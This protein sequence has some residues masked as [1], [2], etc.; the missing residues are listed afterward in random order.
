MF[1]YSSLIL[2]M[3]CL[4]GCNG[5][6][7]SDIFSSESSGA[8]SSTVASP[9]TAESS[10]ARSATEHEASSANTISSMV[11]V[12]SSASTAQSSANTQP[13]RWQP[14]PLTTWQWQ[15][16]GS[17]NENYPVQA[18]DIDL[19][20]TSA[21]T[22]AALQTQG[23]RII[24]YFSAGSYEEWRQDALSFPT[25]ALGNNLDGWP[26]ERWLD[27][28]N[29]S[30][31]NIMKI[32]LNLAVDKG[33][34]AIEPD[35]I[36]GYSNPSGF[37]LSAQHQLDYNIFLANEAHSRGLS[38]GLKNDVDQVRDLVNY[39]DFAINEECF[40]YQECEM[41]APFIRANKAVFNAEYK[42]LWRNNTAERNTLCT[43]SINLQFS[44][45]ILPLDLDDA[46]RFSCVE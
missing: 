13:A 30:V 22:I 19:F 2:A 46:F 7:T 3:L 8:R 27:I 40:E 18:Y 42:A 4:I 20:E 32:R 37:S 23:I 5:D 9:A 29:E 28:R 24:C 44:T 31:R 12:N 11:S 39:Y 33:C 10:S 36:D 38:I 41:L 35:N 45:L 21:D 16:T 1:K 14:A 34:D 17:L 25:S 43:Q 6:S 26:G 15:L